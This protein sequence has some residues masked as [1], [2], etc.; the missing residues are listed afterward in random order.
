MR[1]K[2]QALLVIAICLT[3]CCETQKPTENQIIK[4]II[5]TPVPTI[6]TAQTEL[7]SEDVIFSI[8]D[9]VTLQECACLCIPK[10][11]KIEKAKVV[12]EL[13]AGRFLVCAIEDIEEDVIGIYDKVEHIEASMNCTAL[14]CSTEDGFSFSIETSNKTYDNFIWKSGNEVFEGE[15]TTEK[16]IILEKISD[17]TGWYQDGSGYHL[18]VTYDCGAVRFSAT[19]LEE[20]KEVVSIMI[21]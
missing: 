8:I 14:Q 10:E 11:Y 12:D 15:C 3:G 9:N 19:D 17:N 2:L 20:L 7:K 21:G 6:E 13:K 4:E 16:S 1:R 18:I 5:N